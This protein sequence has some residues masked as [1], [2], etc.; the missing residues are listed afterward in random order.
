MRIA[1]LALFL[2]GACSG[3][4][5]PAPKPGADGNPIIDKNPDSKPADPAIPNGPNDRD[6]SLATVDGAETTLSK[7]RAPV[8]VVAMWASFCAPCLRELSLIEALHNKYKNNPEVTVLL[9]SIDDFDNDARDTIKR[10]MSEKSLTIPSFIDHKRQLIDRV[11]PRD[12]SGQVHYTVPM[13]AIIDS[14]FGLRRKLDLDDQ[15][16]EA[17]FVGGISTLVD[18]ALRG[19]PPPPDK[20]Y[21]PPLG[22]AITKRSITLTIPRLREHQIKQYVDEFRHTL[23]EMYPDLHDHQLIPLMADIEKKLRIGGTFKI[24]IP[25]GHTGTH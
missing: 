9:V 17:A 14:H 18:A 12:R 15:V 13:V 3:S 5:S 1:L 20:P 16:G 6:I 8:T 10:I 25:M 21:E 11:A 2:A 22:G 24:E 4:P 19:D 23:K 7:H